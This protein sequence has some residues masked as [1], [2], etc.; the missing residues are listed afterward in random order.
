MVE[1]RCVLICGE[2]TE[3]K[4]IAHITLELLG[5]GRK[6]ADELGE[7]LLAAVVGS[8]VSKIADE[9]IYFGADKVYVVDDPLLKEYNGDCYVTVLERLCGEVKPDII[10][11]GQ[12]PI[13]IDLAPRLSFRLKTRLTTDCIDLGIDPETKLLLLTKPVY[14]GN[15]LAVYV[16]E[17][18]PQMATVRS[19]TMTALARD[20]SRKGKVIQFDPEIDAFLIRTELIEKVE[21]E[22]KGVKLEDADVVVS[23]GRGIGG[24]DGFRRIEELAKLLGGA[25]GAS[26]PPCDAGWVTSTHQV[27]LTGRIVT[28]NLYIAVGI[29]GASQHLAGMSESKKI[30]AINKDPGA[31]IFKVAHYGVIGD[32]REVLPAFT[33]KVRELK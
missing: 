27:G 30:V 13:G 19:K 24:P 9:T 15:A 11:M 8:D 29:S 12:T 3:Q 20:D 28:P 4:Q 33:E 5:I 2:V 26:R 10:L 17:T 14:G 18:K 6:L 7:E 21:E 22:W 31:N 32:Y 16:S 25:T 1:H 23:G